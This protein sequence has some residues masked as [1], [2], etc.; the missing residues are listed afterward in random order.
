MNTVLQVIGIS[1]QF[2]A[3]TAAS[4]ISLSLGSTEILG[5]IGANGAGK[6][7]FLNMVTGYLRPDSGIIRYRGSDITSLEPREITNL[8][9]HRSFQIPQIFPT[10][11]VF[12]NV[13]ISIGIAGGITKNRWVPLRS[14]TSEAAVVGLLERYRISDYRDRQ[15]GLLPQGVRKLLDIC[16]AMVGSPRILLLD[17]PTSGVSVEEKMVMMDTILEVIRPREVGILFVEH[18]MEVV[19]QYANRVVA[20]SEGE[21]IADG[22]PT[23]VMSD[24]EVRAMVVGSDLQSN[25]R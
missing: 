5:I 12:D 3:V 2:G 23:E 25:P 14:Q 4:N 7:T 8:G 17:E 22:L 18:D 15:A 9:I 10:L 24:A 19:E 6:T 16:M 21:I 20:F 1:K 13:L 11:T